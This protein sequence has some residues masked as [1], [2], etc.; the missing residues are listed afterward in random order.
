MRG[1][2][3]TKHNS[4]ARA[5]WLVRAALLLRQ[6]HALH[7]HTGNRSRADGRATSLFT[8]VTSAAV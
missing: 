7:V 6:L 4:V 2:N 1:R 5:Y 3:Y 8:R